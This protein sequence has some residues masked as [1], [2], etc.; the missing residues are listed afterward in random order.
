MPG[1]K[2]EVGHTY[3]SFSEKTM[4]RINNH[5]IKENVKTNEA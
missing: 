5:I 1:V 3:G 4:Q 2:E